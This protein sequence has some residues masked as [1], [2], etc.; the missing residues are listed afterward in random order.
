MRNFVCRRL[1]RFN[2]V[3]VQTWIV[4]L[5]PGCLCFKLVGELILKAI[6]VA[7]PSDPSCQPCVIPRST[8]LFP[9]RGM[10]ISTLE[11]PAECF[12]NEPR[13]PEFSGNGNF[14]TK[15]PAFIPVNRPQRCFLNAVPLQS[16]SYSVAHYSG[17]A[18]W[19]GDF[20][21]EIWD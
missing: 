10:L 12:R 13:T 2:V 21:T 3:S 4:L 6:R 19:N 20:M 15:A 1:I 9:T 18:F 5:Y 11:F 16:L 14:A 17:I 8:L 7:H